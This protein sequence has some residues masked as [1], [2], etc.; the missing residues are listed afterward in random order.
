[1][2]TKTFQLWCTICSVSMQRRVNHHIT[3]F[4]STIM[5]LC[6]ARRLGGVMRSLIKNNSLSLAMLALF[7]AS[8]F[9]QT[10]TGYTES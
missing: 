10:L 1:M 2:R 6:H 9:G 7:V 4:M 5:Q 8:L 3:T